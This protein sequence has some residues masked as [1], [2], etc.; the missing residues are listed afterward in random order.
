VDN[1]VDKNEFGPVTLDA[2]WRR[3]LCLNFMQLLLFMKINDLK[4][5]KYDSAIT[6]KKISQ[7]S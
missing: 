1:F 7:N 2:A 6:R 3:N 4:E 5:S